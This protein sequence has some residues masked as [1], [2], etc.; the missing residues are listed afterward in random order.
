MS[1]KKD[2]K[3]SL[4]TEEVRKIYTEINQLS[5]KHET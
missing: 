5:V 4:I 2:L 3:D 1:E